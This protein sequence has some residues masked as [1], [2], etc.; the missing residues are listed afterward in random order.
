MKKR[1][2]SMLVAV[3]MLTMMLAGCTAPVANESPPP[4]GEATAAPAE[5]EPGD[6]AQ[7]ATNEW[8]DLIPA[9]LENKKDLDFRLW[10]TQSTDLDTP[11]NTGKNVVWDYVTERTGVTV[12]EVFGNGGQEP[13]AKLTQMIA[14]DI[15]PQLVNMHMSNAPTMMSKFKEGN[16]VHTIDLELVKKYAPN[17]YRWTP[18]AYWQDVTMDDGKIYGIPYGLDINDFD[19]YGLD[20]EL[21]P[22][23]QAYANPR[24]DAYDTWAYTLIRDDVL[25]QIYPQAK[26]YDELQKI[27]DDTGKLTA[28]DMCDIPITTTEEF[29]DFMYRIKDLNLKEGDKDVYAYG[30]NGADNWTGLAVLLPLMTGTVTYNYM[31]Y[32]DQDTHEMKFGY[33]EDWVKDGAL[34]QNRMIRDKVIDPESLIHNSDQYEEKL[35]A[36]RYVMFTD[37]VFGGPEA[38]NTV[39]AE[40]GK[41]YKYRPFLTNVK[42]M[43]G[44]PAFKTVAGYSVVACIF[45]TVPEEDLPQVLSYMDFYYTNEFADAYNWGPASAGLYEEQDG[46]RT[47]KDERFQRHF[48]EGDTSDNLKREDLLGLQDHNYRRMY[49]ISQSVY[50]P[51]IYNDDQILKTVGACLRFP[52]DSERVTALTEVPSYQVWDPPFAGE[53]FDAFWVERQ[54]W[55]QPFMTALTAK[56]DEEFAQKW[57]ECVENLKRYGIE[58][59]LKYN[60]EVGKELWQDIGK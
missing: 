49:G 54:S 36:G 16:L 17:L 42:Q 13:P 19:S 55:D 51:A 32:W 5:S 21:D 56:S 9:K 37:W 1:F 27:L 11:D 15:M 44:M 41:T 35:R 50:T 57:N 33:L 34:L 47:F 58:E 8:G 14:G 46:K 43:E 40:Q 29:V 18:E 6:P 10:W 20:I 25:K 39:L 23:L 2:L 60:T 7:G 30:Y 52:L 59:V 3:L 24:N 48:V 28:D 45:K 26:S 38:L 4:S 31:S 22:R 53:L 12:S